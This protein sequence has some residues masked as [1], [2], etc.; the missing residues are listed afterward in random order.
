M[1]N[2]LVIISTL[3]RSICFD[4]TENM[5]TRSEVSK[6]RDR[7]GVSEKGTMNLIV[8]RRSTIALS[9]LF[10]LAIIGFQAQ[11]SRDARL[12]YFDTL[13]TSLENVT[14]TALDED[15]ASFRKYGERVATAAG[16]AAMV[17][18]A[19]MRWY[20]S[21]A[22][23]GLSCLSVVMLLFALC[24][25]NYY[26]RSR[27]FLMVAWLFSFAVPFAI[28]TVP[29]RCFVNWDQFNY[30][31][32]IFMKGVAAHYQLDQRETE[33]VAGCT[34]ITDPSNPQ[35]LEEARD[36][37][38]FVCNTVDDW[39]DGF[40]NWISGDA[41]ARAEENCRKAQEALQDGNVDLALEY[42]GET[43]DEVIDTIDSASQEEGNALKRMQVVI[44]HQD[45]T[46]KARVAA[47]LLI[48]LL[49]ALWALKGMVPAAVAIAPA[50]LRGALTI[51]TLVP[52][53]SIPGMFVILLP[54]LYCPLVWCIYNIAFQLTGTLVF[55][56]GLL[57]LA[58]APMSYV[59]LGQ[60]YGITKPMDDISNKRM[61]NAMAYL[62]MALLTVAAGLC[63]YF[64]LGQDG[65]HRAL[66]KK[67][68]DE[69]LRAPGAVTNLVV[70]TVGK[71]LVTTLAGV[72]FM[73][74]EIAEQREFERF[75]ETGENLGYSKTHGLQSEGR[76]RLLNM[77]KQKN[78][79]LDDLCQANRRQVGVGCGCGSAWKGREGRAGEA[80]SVVQTGK[81]KAAVRRKSSSSKGS[82]YSGKK[83]FGG[84][85]GGGG[86]GSSSTMQMN[87]KA[88]KQFNSKKWEG[89]V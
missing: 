86:R 88:Q 63:G 78:A 27:K 80:M 33:V 37:V 51:K 23:W 22:N 72:D 28:S 20:C 9:I 7:P 58:F 4:L 67:G 49:N 68:I 1:C 24:Y 73:A 70:T 54:W 29:T 71:Y 89:V 62:N 52:Q 13:D 31:S 77:L 25:W 82:A 14:Y 43:C 8:W 47:E 39:D 87:T 79:R 38:S 84:G 40:I 66:A 18:V 32:H 16:A 42:A 17:E 3:A 55:F 74:H 57:L 19:L 36:S 65:D 83:Y 50:L 6:L 59:A 64:A 48:S 75:L 44:L 81:V 69:Y 41:I 46:T 60:V 76:F 21:V 85:G 11:E 56:F 26:H 2:P 34:I 61:M 53:S 10:M 5:A 35:T 15:S 30:Q 12:M 45:L